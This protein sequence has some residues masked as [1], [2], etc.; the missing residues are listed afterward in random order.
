[1]ILRIILRGENPADLEL[2]DKP[3]CPP[4]RAGRIGGDE[5]LSQA[6]HRFFPAVDWNLLADRLR[7]ATGDKGSRFLGAISREF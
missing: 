1:M 7:A 4:R 3:L 2:E 5:E 6:W